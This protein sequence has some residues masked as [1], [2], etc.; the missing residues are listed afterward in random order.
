MAHNET[1]GSLALM[2]RDAALALTR[3]ADALDKR[4]ANASSAH[5]PPP[6]APARRPESA[7]VGAS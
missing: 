3:L 4:P 5:P 1:S 2:A 7:G 6:P